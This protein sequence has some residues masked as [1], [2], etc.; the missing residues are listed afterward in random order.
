MDIDGL[1]GSVLRSKGGM[2]A[3]SSSAGGGVG[4]KAYLMVR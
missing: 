1:V 3:S 2:S 4:A